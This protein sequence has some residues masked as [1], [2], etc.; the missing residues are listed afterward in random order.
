M[1]EKGVLSQ[2]PG[3][4][5]SKTRKPILQGVVTPL[6]MHAKMT[7]AR[8]TQAM[9]S[10]WN[11]L[12]LALPLLSCLNFARVAEAQ[13]LPDQQTSQATTGLRA[14]ADKRGLLLGT[15]IRIGL[16]QQKADNGQYESMVRN[17]FNLVEPDNSFKPPS[18]WKAKETYDFGATDFL[19]GAPG[20]TGWA[21]AN[22][23][24]VRGHVLIY[25][26]DDGWTLP[27]WLVSEP[28]RVV[29]KSIEDGLTRQE[30]TELLRKYIFALVGR[31]K[32]KIAQWDVINETIDDGKNSNPF[33]LRNSFW[34]RKLGVDYVE[35]A[36]RFAHQAD[37]NARLFYNDYGIE[38]INAKSDAVLT[39]VKYLRAKG[40]PID[41]V[42]MQWHIGIGHQLRPGDI[43]Y[44]NAQRFKDA[45]IDFMITELDVAMPV[46]V[47]EP[48][49][50]LYGLTPLNTPDLYEQA[51][52]YREVLRYALSF[53]NCRGVNVWEFCDKYSWI[54]DFTI[55][56]LK[57]N[58]P[59]IPQGAA[60]LLDANYQ[61]KP[62][63]WQ[64]REELS[65]AAD[66]S[67]H[68]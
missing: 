8:D 50:P 19:L 23:M 15:A 16:L 30:A 66:A 26:R 58:P 38:G 18:I 36:F 11:K 12:M 41:G 37:P 35:L 44:Q 49:D 45:G 22:N 54:P 4:A 48:N 65:Q 31:Y 34:F 21:Q 42:G 9:T 10:T 68:K 39:L 25:G 20:Q 14:L 56:R 28:G 32:G 61:P 62:A 63:Y 60:T 53:S 64:L 7:P 33:N 51:H 2:A 17:N 1:G 27:N 5:G 43:Y 24:A 6:A 40:V 59:G 47:H 55:G 3:A 46:V 57:E 13:I 52:L 67:P 29:N